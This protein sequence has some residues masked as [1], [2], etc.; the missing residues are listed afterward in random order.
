MRSKESSTP[1]LPCIL[2]STFILCTF[3]TPAIHAITLTADSFRFPLDRSIQVTGGFGAFEETYFHGYHLGVDLRAPAGT[4]VYAIANGIIKRARR[5]VGLGYAVHIQHCLDD[6]LCASAESP[7]VTSVYYHLARLE[8]DGDGITGKKLS[9]DAPNNTIN[10]GDLIGYITGNSNDD[11]DAPHLHMGIRQSDYKILGDSRTNKWFYTGYSSVFRVDETRIIE[12]QP[13]TDQETIRSEWCDPLTYILEWECVVLPETGIIE[14]KRIDR[15]I[16][17]LTSIPTS[18]RVNDVISNANSAFFPNLLVDNNTTTHIAEVT[19][20]PEF[21]EQ[22]AFCD[23][24][25]CAL[26]PGDEGV[27]YQD[28]DCDGSF[29][30]LPIAVFE[31]T[32]TRIVFLYDECAPGYE[33]EANGVKC[34]LFNEPPVPVNLIEGTFTGTVTSVVNNGIFA[35]GNI[36]VGDPVTAHFQYDTNAP[37]ET[38]LVEEFGLSYDFIPAA[39]FNSLS[40][41]IDD[42]VSEF[43]WSSNN[44]LNVTVGNDNPVPQGPFGPIIRFDEFTVRFEAINTV[45]EGVTR[46][47]LAYFNLGEAFSASP[48]L[49]ESINLPMSLADLDPTKVNSSRGGLIQSFREFNGD[50]YS[51]QFEIDLNSFTL[52]PQGQVPSVP[53][54][55]IIDQEAGDPRGGVAFEIFNVERFK[56]LVDPGEPLNE[57]CE[58]GPC[59]LA[60]S[61]VP[62]VSQLVG[63]EV[64]LSDVDPTQPVAPIEVRLNT[65]HP[66]T[67]ATLA[68]TTLTPTNLLRTPEDPVSADWVFFELP[69]TLVPGETYVIEVSST[70]KRWGWVTGLP[71][72]DGSACRYEHPRLFCDAPTG[73]GDIDFA[74]RTYVIP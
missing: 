51:I 38:V 62:A 27:T 31:N 57:E 48:G 68:V 39:P 44:Q 63:V 8:D 55:S 74:F 1:W 35:P 69:Q 24:P 16:N 53:Q 72:Q 61:F 37:E 13:N 32:L 45:R 22:V 21:I 47:D 64:L 4:P 12:N 26:I 11:G 5:M 19:D 58:V 3:L 28:A 41:T 33:K 49:L 46:N 18:A 71:Y 40:F 17:N 60:Q 10:K 66:G 43:S 65:F 70:T 56:P 2:L 15:N 29:C 42:G 20:L 14:I 7:Q 67:S 52:G 30:I 9:V 23:D 34:L 6:T 50:H 36:S 25:G 54:N 59:T 73:I